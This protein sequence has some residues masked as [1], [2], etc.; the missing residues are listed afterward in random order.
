LAILTALVLA[1][2]LLAACG[3][4]PNGT[5]AEPTATIVRANAT[6]T[7]L[8]L[9]TS[10]TVL[11]YS[12]Q[13]NR[14]GPFQQ[15]SQDA[16]KV[17]ELYRALD[18]LPYKVPAIGCPLYAEG[19]GYELSFMQGNTL[20]LQV[21]LQTCYGVSISN[22]PDCRQWAPA[23]TEQIAATLGVPVSALGPTDKLLNT[24]GPN[25]PFAQPAPTPPILP[26]CF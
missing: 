4:S 18:T 22:S 7:S 24:A 13:D 15:T 25:G 5:K 2:V 8:P 20:V 26:H 1:L 14:V 12:P 17:Q 6:A 23:L 11:R 19:F 16:A 3:A 10:L 21:M 9:P